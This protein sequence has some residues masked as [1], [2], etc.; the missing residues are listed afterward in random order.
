MAN[1]LFAYE[2]QRVLSSNETISVAAHPGGA[3]SELSRYQSGFVRSAFKLMSQNAAMGALPT[4]RAATD[5]SVA[6]GQYYEPGGLLSLRGF[7]VLCQSSPRSHD[8]AVAER[9]WSVSEQL[10]GVRFGI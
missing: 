1:L 7:P 5:P 3:T 6:G 8:V 9:L 4:L 10:T 2:L